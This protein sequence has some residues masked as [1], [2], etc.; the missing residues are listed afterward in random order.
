MEKEEKHLSET[1]QAVLTIISAALVLLGWSIG[2]SFAVFFALLSMV[3]VKKYAVNCYNRGMDK[4]YLF[5][6]SMCAILLVIYE[7]LARS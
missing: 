5:A 1:T 3:V 2:S 7:I 6:Y 4:F